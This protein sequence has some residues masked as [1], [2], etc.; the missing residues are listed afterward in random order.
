VWASIDALALLQNQLNETVC[1]HIAKGLSTVAFSSGEDVIYR[2]LKQ[3]QHQQVADEEMRKDGGIPTYAETLLYLRC[4]RT[5]GRDDILE[6]IP[7]PIPS[8]TELNDTGLLDPDDN[9]ALDEL[10]FLARL[11]AKSSEVALEESC[12]TSIRPHLTHINP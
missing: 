7:T 8:I 3:F 12:S 4:L 5:L 2:E 6:K 9:A 11:Q 1:R 10:L